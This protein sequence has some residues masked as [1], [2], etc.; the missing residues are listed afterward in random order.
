MNNYATTGLAIAT[1]FGGE[2]L[3]KAHQNLSRSEAKRRA[4]SV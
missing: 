1:R 4:G 2:L 3:E